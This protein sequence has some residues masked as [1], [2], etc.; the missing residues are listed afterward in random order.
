M[1]VGEG[2]DADADDALDEEQD[3]RDADRVGNRRLHVGPV[4]D[5]D[6]LLEEREHG[7]ED[8]NADDEAA[9]HRGRVDHVVRE[10]EQEQLSEDN[11][12]GD[13]QEVQRIPGPRQRP[14]GKLATRP[15]AA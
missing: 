12:D 4:P 7:E 10:L 9:E 13:P 14:L 8:P 2:R 11:D 6:R 5:A 15:R 1:G 3:E